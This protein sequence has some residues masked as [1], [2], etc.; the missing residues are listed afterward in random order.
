MGIFLVMLVNKK[1][2]VFGDANANEIGGHFLVMLLD[3]Q[4]VVMQIN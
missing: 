1:T 2:L 3:S 4:Y